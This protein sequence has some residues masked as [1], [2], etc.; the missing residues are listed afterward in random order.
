MSGSTSS[1]MEKVTNYFN[2]FTDVMEQNIRGVHVCRQLFVKIF[3]NITLQITCYSVALVS[4]TIA[5]RKVRPVSHFFFF[6]RISVLKIVLIF[7]LVD[8]EDHLMFLIIS[9]KRNAN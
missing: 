2:R 6:V 4:L 9:L 8:F 1:T 3:C 5:V 7:S